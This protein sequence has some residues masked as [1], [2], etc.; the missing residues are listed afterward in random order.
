[1][2]RYSLAIFDLDGTLLDSFP[3][4]LR[5]VNTMADKHRFRR[6]A[7][8]DVETLR[9]R[10]S[11][12]IIAALGVPMWKLPMIVREMRALKSMHLCDITLFPGIDAMLATLHASGIQLAMVSSDSEA[13]VRRSLGPAANLMSCYACGAALFGKATK[14][15]QVIRRLNV[16]ADH[17]ICIGDEIRDADAARKA[18]L[19]FGAVTWGYASAEALARISPALIFADPDDVVSKLAA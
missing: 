1:M 17:A 14:F 7:E 3:W 13:N 4:F 19:D 12:E 18:G 9:G 11:R 5:I 8:A 15:S 10:T 16:M 6:I 2:T